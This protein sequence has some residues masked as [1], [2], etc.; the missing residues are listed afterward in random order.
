MSSIKG[1]E[2][3][4]HKIDRYSEEFQKSHEKQSTK[5]EPLI[6]CGVLEFFQTTAGF[7]P[8]AYQ[9]KLLLD[10]NQFIAARWSRQSGKSLCLAVLS[11]YT[12]LSSPNRREL[13]LAPSFRQS[14]RMLRRISSFLSRL[15][16]NVLDGRPLKT[17][18][19]FVNGSTIEA[20]PNNPETI[21]GE[22]TNMI[23]LDEAN[24]IQDDKELYD[25]IVYSL[26]TTNGRLIATSTP[27]SRDSLFYVMCNDDE[28]F[29]D[30]SRHHVTYLGAL[31]PNGPL[32]RSTL[33][34]LERQMREDPWRWKREM[35]AEF[36]EDEE[37][38][39]SYSLITSCVDPELEY[40][41]DEEIDSMPDITDVDRR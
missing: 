39:L 35:M 23:I 1:G 17:R 26:A 25:A 41:T 4:W 29:G 33:E 9:E 22:T 6:S 2:S 7:K 8:T 27:G 14:R 10:E 40:L 11:L 37:A 13:I 34:K 19:E 28:T 12:A 18:L 5:D 36:S 3:A 21:R 31:E 30:F 15:P 38:W 20:F 16:E 32:K 24:Y